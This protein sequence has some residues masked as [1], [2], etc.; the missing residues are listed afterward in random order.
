[1]GSCVYC[2][3]PQQALHPDFQEDTTGR[4]VQSECQEKQQNDGTLST[5]HSRDGVPC[6]LDL[7]GWSLEVAAVSQSQ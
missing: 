5:A 1:M 4:S 6:T 7:A 3:S 2:L